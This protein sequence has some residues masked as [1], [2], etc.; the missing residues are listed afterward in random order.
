MQRAV[1]EARRHEEEKRKRKAEKRNKVEA[2]CRD[3]VNQV[4]ESARV[5]STKI[6]PG[7]LA[8]VAFMQQ[9]EKGKRPRKARSPS[10]LSG[11]AYIVS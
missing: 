10:K 1:E 11:S 5:R 2:A 4:S 6:R 9:K 8:S 3:I 7:G